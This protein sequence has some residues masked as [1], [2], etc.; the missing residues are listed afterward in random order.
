MVESLS[1]TRL[2]VIAP[3]SPSVDEELVIHLAMADGLESRRATLISS[4]PISMSGNV[5]FRLELR[6]EDVTP[7]VGKDVTT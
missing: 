1:G 4:H 6:L 7:V 3:S 5:S 2:I